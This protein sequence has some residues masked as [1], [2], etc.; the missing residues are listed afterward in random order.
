VTERFIDKMTLGNGLTLQF[1]DGSRRLAGDRWLVL[2]A[3]VI[4]ID[5]AGAWRQEGP[6][7]PI[8]VEQLRSVLGDT[9]RFRYEKRSHFV[10]KNKKDVVF[11]RL[12]NDFLDTNVSYLS[13]PDFARKFVFGKYRQAQGGPFKWPRQ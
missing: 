5:V 1:Y 7:A 12:K 10:D 11:E 6:D 9:A 8:S 2:F 4:D 13:N 3:A